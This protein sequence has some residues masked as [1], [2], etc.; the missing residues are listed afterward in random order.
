MDSGKGSLFNANIAS[1][2]LCSTSQFPN[3][4][5]AHFLARVRLNPSHTLQ[6]L[7]QVNRVGFSVAGLGLIQ[8]A[9]TITAEYRPA[10]AQRVDIDFKQ[11]TLVR[12]ECVE[13]AGSRP[14]AALVLCWG[15]RQ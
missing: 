11:A 3:S 9:L 14:A 13:S 10:G 5:N 1:C 2:C 12:L 8:G 4:T 6:L 7:W 15:A